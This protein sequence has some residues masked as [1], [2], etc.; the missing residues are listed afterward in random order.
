[1]KVIEKI[2]D[3]NNGDRY[4]IETKECFHCNKTGRVEI[5]TQI[6]ADRRKRETVMSY[7]TMKTVFTRLNSFL[8]P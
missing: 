8:V 1:M 7:F 5:Q 4:V 2:Y 3:F 6:V